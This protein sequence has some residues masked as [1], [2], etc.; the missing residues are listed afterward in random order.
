TLLLVVALVGTTAGCNLQEIIN[1]LRSA[2]FF[3]HTLATVRESGRTRIVDHPHVLTNGFHQR[4][5]AGAA[6]DSRRCDVE[7]DDTGHATC[8]QG[9]APAIWEFTYFGDRSGLNLCANQHFAV[10]S[11]PLA[12]SDIV[13]TDTIGIF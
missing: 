4:D 11:A 9:R 8:L 5:F 3:I 6:G 13:C 1:L 10:F 7:T 12:T 2:G